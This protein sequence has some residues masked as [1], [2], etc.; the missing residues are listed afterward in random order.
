MNLISF[1]DMLK[2]RQAEKTV[3]DAADEMLN[4]LFMLREYYNRSLPKASVNMDEFISKTG[5]KYMKK[6]EAMSNE[7][8][9]FKCEEVVRKGEKNENN[10]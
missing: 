8:L 10:R 4:Y 7:E 1:I 5:E 9:K 6:Y 3:I 2:T